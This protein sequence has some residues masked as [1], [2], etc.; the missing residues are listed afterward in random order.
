MVRPRTR[1]LAQYTDWFARQNS[2]P[3]AVGRKAVFFRA[4]FSI[5]LGCLIAPEAFG[6]GDQNAQALKLI[7]ATADQICQS[8]PLEHTDTGLDLTGE[9]KAKLGGVVGKLADLG[10]SGTAKY[11]SN[12]SMGVLQ[13]DIVAAIRAGNS[14]KLEVFRT[15]ERDLITT[16]HPGFPGPATPSPSTIEVDKCLP[17]GGGVHG[18]PFQGWPTEIKGLVVRDD[19]NNIYAVGILDAYL[20]GGSEGMRHDIQFLPGEKLTEIH[21]Q[22]GEYVHFLRVVTNKRDVSF[23][24]LAGGAIFD[25]K[26]PPGHSIIA[27]C[28]HYGRYVDAIGVVVR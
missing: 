16:S 2:V 12:H 19:R 14:C 17:L 27:L 1:L 20:Y 9:A 21:G 5:L 3:V 22:A 4:C 25:Y 28:G 13:Q 6:Q 23:G 8:A 15:L 26:V 10:I 7:T 11:T 18:S 24:R